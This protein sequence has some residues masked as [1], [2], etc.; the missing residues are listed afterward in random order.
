M[1]IILPQI[2]VDKVFAAYNADLPENQQVQDEPDPVLPNIFIWQLPDSSIIP[3]ENIADEN[4]EEKKEAE[5]PQQS[6]EELYLSNYD[7]VQYKGYL[8]FLE[9]T[10]AISLKQEDKEF[11]LNLS[12][13]QKF[14]SSKLVNAKDIKLPTTSFAQNVLAR[15]TSDLQYNIAPL[16]HSS[17]ISKGGFSVG[18]AYNE[19]IDNADLGFTT[20]FYTKYETKYFALKTAYEKNA[21]VA[22]SL[23]V[24]QF[25][26]APEL[27]LNEYI[28]IKDVLTSDI[29]RDRKKNELVL[30]IKPTKED[31]LRFEFGAGQ[32]FDANS[33][34]IKS[35]VKF[36][37]QFKW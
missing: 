11:A 3:E 26:V 36:S 23:V 9:D 2:A 4:S 14:E 5:E 13:P 7:N 22:Y 37:T 30:S 21:G 24:D 10:D 32:T 19:S 34:L 31:R 6:E 16:D 1:S 15:S 20:S 28:S 35:Q 8:E 12:V 33:E 17:E 29:T 27:K 18:T 25:S